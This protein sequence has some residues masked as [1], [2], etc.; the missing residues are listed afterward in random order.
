[1]AP[2]VIS[3]WTLR[4]DAGRLLVP[5]GGNAE[6]VRLTLTERD[7]GAAHEVPS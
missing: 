3:E 5:E 6:L 2:I 7:A 4:S 1:M